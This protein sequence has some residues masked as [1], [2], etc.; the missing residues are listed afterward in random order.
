MENTTLILLNM[1]LSNYNFYFYTQVYC[2]HTNTPNSTRTQ[3]T[4]RLRVKF[5]ATRG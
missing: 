1:A 4:G 5:R 3:I 2:M